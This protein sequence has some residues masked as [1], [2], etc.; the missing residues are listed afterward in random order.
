[1][2]WISEPSA[3]L[4]CSRTEGQRLRVAASFIFLH[5][6]IETSLRADNSILTW[7]NIPK[8]CLWRT[9][10]QPLLSPYWTLPVLNS[11]ILGSLEKTAD[12]T[13]EIYRTAKS[14]QLCKSR[15]SSHI[16]KDIFYPYEYSQNICLCSATTFSMERSGVKSYCLYENGTGDC[17]P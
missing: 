2:H 4:H 14:V 12:H 3:I 15:W 6:L 16:V 7:S 11:G 17:V 5:P 13:L 8:L 1:M 9:S 10:P